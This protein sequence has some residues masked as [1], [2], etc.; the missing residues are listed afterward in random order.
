MNHWNDLDLSHFGKA[1]SDPNLTD[2]LINSA[3]TA[4][5][6]SVIGMFLSISYLITIKTRDE[7]QRKW[8]L[9]ILSL[10]IFL[11]DIL[12]GLSLVFIIKLMNITTGLVPV[13]VVHIIFNSFLSY[14]ILRQPIIKYPIS[15]INSAK[16][17]GYSTYNIISDVVIP[18]LKTQF[19]GCFLLCFIYSFDDFL[20]TFLL[21][22]STFQTFPLYMYSKIKFGLSQN[23][24][25][26]AAIY[27]AVNIFI[28]ALLLKSSFKLFPDEK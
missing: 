17:F 28:F 15:Q 12:W 3:L 26:V 21:S 25:V 9:Y 7:N 14:L 27:T 6:S 23:I 22:G 24:V 10:P 13:L 5:T 20:L 16:I 19:I 8:H 4:I 1:F 2:S 11:P 18:N